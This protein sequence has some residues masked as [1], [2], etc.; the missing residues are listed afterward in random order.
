MLTMLSNTSYTDLCTRGVHGT[1]RKYLENIEK[2]G[3]VRRTKRS[4]KLDSWNA[5]KSL[6]AGKRHQEPIATGGYIGYYRP[7]DGTPGTWS[8]RH[9]DLE[10]GRTKTRS[11]GKADDFSPADGARVLTYQQAQEV[12]QNWFRSLANSGFWDGG[13]EPDGKLSVRDVL[14][15]YFKD[16]QGRG[17]KGIKQAMQSAAAWIMPKLGQVQVARLTR[18]QIEGW[19]HWL[20]ESPKRLK[21]RAGQ[22]QAYAEPPS[23]DDEI[24]ARRDSA[25]R[26]LTILKAALNFALDRE[27]TNAAPVWQRVKPFRGTTKA[28]VRFLKDDE[29]V[30]LVNAIEGQDFKDLV[31][32]ALLT[33]AR[34]GELA[35]LRCYDYD[36]C[37]KSVFIAKS[38][39]GKS[40]HVTLND[41]GARLF[42]EA[43]GKR[44]R[45]DDLIF[46]CSSKRKARE[47]AAW[48]K[49]DQARGMKQA[50]K[51]AGLEY[52]SFH[53][54]RHSYASLLIN[55]GV[56][57]YVVAEQLGQADTR[58]VEKHYGHLLPSYKAQRI[59]DRLPNLRLAGRDE[60]GQAQVQAQQA[61]G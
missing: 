59:R 29:Q 31:R 47:G 23:T 17:M 57:L 58:M 14:E 49:G 11:L 50:C 27:L 51:K 30:R 16:A 38:K 24:R 61:S 7:G 9:K 26:V 15:A 53:D 1:K 21:T 22:P 34:L 25:N 19:L 36:P 12:A 41:D 6:E 48:Q 2:G 45:P 20:A 33:G 13:A 4:A 54:L 55:S 60:R 35:R 28:R 32:A 56:E 52:V 10:T 18:K 46:Q 40:R 42:D 39:S 44:S 8:A 3:S 43:V 5:R 37:N